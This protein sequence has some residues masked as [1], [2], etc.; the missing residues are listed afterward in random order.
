MSA[1]NCFISLPCQSGWLCA[2]MIM[3]YAFFQLLAAEQADAAAVGVF[4]N[5]FFV[6]LI[7]FDQLIHVSSNLV[8]CISILLNQL[9]AFLLKAG[10]DHDGVNGQTLG[11]RQIVGFFSCAAI[12]VNAA[13]EEERGKVQTAVSAVAAANAFCVQSLQ[14]GV[15]GDVAELLGMIADIVI[16]IFSSPYRSEHISC[17]GNRQAGGQSC[18]TDPE[19]QR[20]RRLRA[21]W[22]QGCRLHQ[23][24]E[25]WTPAG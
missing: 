22:L 5:V 11:Y 23:Q 4:P 24:G 2:S 3:I 10:S 6:F 20:A 16:C 21:R 14:Q 13:L 12:A 18:R 8:V 25:A 1:M 7:V 17:R 9:V 19:Q 15:G